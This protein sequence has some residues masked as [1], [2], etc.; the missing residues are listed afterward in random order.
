MNLQFDKDKLY[1]DCE[2]LKEKYGYEINPYTMEQFLYNVEH[3]INLDYTLESLIKE[4]IMD[5][6]TFC[7]TVSYNTI[8]TACKVLAKVNSINFL[9]KYYS[10]YISEEAIEET[11]EMIENPTEIYYIEYENDMRG[12][13]QYSN[14][15]KFENNQ[16]DLNSVVEELKEHPM[17]GY[18]NKFIEEVYKCL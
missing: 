2:S 12:I 7:H 17:W 14:N 18:S 13:F 5:F 3:T 1:M 11:K 15:I 8:Y 16:I 4:F 9:L 6:Y 10:D